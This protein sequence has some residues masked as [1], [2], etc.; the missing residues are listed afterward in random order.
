[1]GS[2]PERSPGNIVARAPM[3]AP[4]A[5]LPEAFPRYP[6]SWYLFCDSNDLAER[7]LSKEMLGT[8]LVAFRAGSAR[9]T[10]MEGRCSHMSADLG[11]GRVVQGRIQCPFHHWEYDAGGR[12]ARIPGRSRIPEFARQ[13]VYP[14]EER[15]GFLFVFNGAEPL[16]QLPFFFESDPARFVAGSPFRFI[17]DCSWYM[18]A[19]NAFDFDH[20]QAVHDRELVGSPVIDSPHPLARRSRFNAVVTGNSV[21]DR[22]IR[23]FAGNSVEVS[24]TNWGG[25]IILVSGFFRR[26]RSHMLISARPIAAD[27]TLVEVVVLAGRGSG[28]GA[29][30]LWIR[31]WFTRAFFQDDIARLGGIRYNPRSLTLEDRDLIDYFDW[32]ASLP[33][34]PAGDREA[35]KEAVL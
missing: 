18:L 9:Q 30:G 14:A 21:C 3:P 8:R 20:F 35:D 5:I 28:A 27:Q 16:F 34:G 7:P 22:L 11:R 31:R 15:H 32:A 13:Q 6:A 10:I 1:M 17:A 29:L 2:V 4:R 33:S 12:C 25:T 24:I 19:S 26:A 23:G